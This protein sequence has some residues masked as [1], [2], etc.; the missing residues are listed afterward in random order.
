[1]IL[2]K[3]RQYAETFA[4]QPIKDAVI[5]VPAFMNQAE[6]RAM[7]L[8]AELGGLNVLQLI[9]DNAAGIMSG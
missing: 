4:D 9:G 8:A 5:T 7:L 1:M 2:E 3:A 6:R